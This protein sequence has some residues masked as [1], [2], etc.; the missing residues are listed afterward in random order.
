MEHA[1]APPLPH[2][3]AGEL[4]ELLRAAIDRPSYAALALAQ[5]GAGPTLAQAGQ[6][7][8]AVATASAATQLLLTGQLHAEFD[9]LAAFLEVA[10]L[11]VPVALLAAFL[12]IHVSLRAL[13][14]AGAV[15]LL[16]AGLLAVCLLPLVAFVAIVADME[17]VRAVSPLIHGSMIGLAIPAVALMTL[18]AR[19]CGVLRCLDPSKRAAF[20]SR[21]IQ[22]GLLVAFLA[23]AWHLV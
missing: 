12:Q 16:H 13:L 21:C 18:L 11:L 19:T 23:R 9:G 22:A 4:L 5:R 20:F 15:G 6:G 7:Q 17:G 10:A 2:R 1:A 3:H 14:G 8:V